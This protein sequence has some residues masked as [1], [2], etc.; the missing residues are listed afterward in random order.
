M[1]KRIVGLVIALISVHHLHAQ[2][3][4]ESFAAR[5]QGG[6]LYGIHQADFSS[7]GDVIDC[8][9]LGTGTGLN[10][11]ASAVLEFPFSDRLGLGVGIGWSGRSAT[12]SN[13]NTYPIRDTASGTDGTL[14]ANYELAATLGYLEIQ[15]DL[16]LAL[17]GPYHR[18]TLGLILGPR[19]S[20][21]TSA[22]FI[23]RE[24]VE[25]PSNATFVVNGSRTQERIIADAPLSAR[26]SALLGFSAGL[27]SFIP[28]GDH[29][30]VVPAV[31]FD[32]FT[33]NV[34][35]DAPWSTYGVRAEIGIRYSSGRVDSVQTF[36]A[37]PPPMIVAAP[38]QVMLAFPS[39]V[40]AIEAG[41]QLRATT[42]IVNAVFFDSASAAVPTSYRRSL[43][44]SRVPEDPVAAHAWVL[45]R[46]AHLIEQNADARIVL[47]GATSGPDTEP[48]GEPLA[49]ERANAVREILVRMGV[50]RSHITVR[51]RVSPRVPS[52]A[53]FP[54][55]REENRRVDILVE[56]APLQEWVS[57]ER[58]AMVTGTLEVKAMR[59]GGGVEGLDTN[60]MRI[61]VHG[62]DTMMKG[63]VVGTRVPVQIPLEQDQ[64][65]ITVSTSA[66]SMGAAAQRDTVIQVADLP[67]TEVDLRTDGFSAVL[68]FEYNS[69]VLTDDVKGLLRQL[70]E[71]LPEGSTIRIQGSADALGSQA[72]NRELSEQRAEN[73]RQF[74]RSIVGN[75]LTLEAS[76][77]SEPFSDDTPQG[78]FLNR[79]IRVTAQT[80]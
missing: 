43:D 32:Y 21:P 1:S 13:Q 4:H 51:G 12:F 69:S 23:Q 31:S 57:T 29:W 62:T 44:G 58:F 70:A 72:R 10:G 77:N 26:S 2:E 33:T 41:N 67:R 45:P 34:V 5:L 16:R 11:T 40:G 68:R 61:R 24:T 28:I 78:R 52:N 80:P 71:R 75:K 6:L 25:S 22:T 37:P 64:P 63:A 73:T 60:A 27:E 48:E 35:S 49:T 56:N 17:V 8:G 19:I 79:S 50:P 74:I 66:A 15:P 38:P 14:V 36:A 18:R 30:N 42:P 20:L 9:L 46:I 55:G 39:F 53:E 76:G 65:T 59:T 47:E 7:S 3:Y 54:G